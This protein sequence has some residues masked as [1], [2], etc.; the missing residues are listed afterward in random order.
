MR[1]ILFSTLLGFA[2]CGGETTVKD[3][4][5]PESDTGRTAPKDER[6]KSR[7][8]EDDFTE[9]KVAAL[10]APTYLEGIQEEAQNL[11]REGVQAVTSET[12]D[13]ALAAKRFQATIEKDKGFLEAW[14]NLGMSLERQGKHNDALQI[15]ERALTENPGNVSANAYIAKL[16][17]GKARASALKGKKDEQAQW[18]DKAKALLDQV[19]VQAASDTAVNNA[20]ALYYLSLGDLDT[21]EKYVREV[22]YVEPSDV[23]G[24]NTRGLIN[25]KRGKYKVAEWI[26]KE[27]VL[28]IDPAST[29]ALT[30]LGYTYIILDLRPLAMKQF[31]KAL[32]LDPQNMDVRMNIA[33]MLLEH[34]DYKAAYEHY[35]LVRDAEPLNL[36]AHEGQC[37]AAFGI[38]GSKAT[39]EDKKQQF[40]A[41][42]ACYDEYLSKTAERRD[43]LLRIAQTYQQKLQDLESLKLAVKYYNRYKDEAKLAP[44]EKEKIAKTVKVVQEIIDAGGMEAMMKEASPEETPPPDGQPAPEGGATPPPEGPTPP[45]AT[46]ETPAPAPSPAPAPDPAP[47][48]APAPSGEPDKGGGVAAPP[49]PVS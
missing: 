7:L 49:V 23:T 28:S 36:E 27:K 32:E 39:P 8:S 14:F 43:L 2:A 17:L 1:A 10:D 40:K 48:P 20:M 18:L 15:Y 24:L 38:G 29:E 4:K 16:Y 34:L 41:A 37:D 13:Y 47:A 5:K 21:A 35:A 46:E 25:L 45:P 26:F 44:E 6:P 9:R 3:D 11:F 19:I 33:A 42:I 30:N 31:K 12:P 22:L